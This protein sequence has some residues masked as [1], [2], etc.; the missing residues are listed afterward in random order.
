METYCVYIH[1]FPNNKNYIGIT[2]NIER[3]FGKDGKGYYTQPKM[4]KAIE[5]YGW[6]NVK[7][8]ILLDGLTK[9]QAEKAEQEF[10]IAYDSIRKGYNI[11]IGGDRVNGTYLLPKLL[12]AIN[13]TRIYIGDIPLLDFISEGKY[14]KA[15]ADLC[16]RA[17]TDVQEKEKRKIGFCFSLTDEADL[18]RLWHEMNYYFLLNDALVNDEPVPVYK[19]Y[20]QAV[21]D[22]FFK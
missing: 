11:T 13:N 20:E 15:F 19:S 17:Y 6:E 10:I 1:T 4:R 5:K 2:K 21:Y 18:G 9:E 12:V 8:R 7:H 3:R 14:E 22:V 16:N